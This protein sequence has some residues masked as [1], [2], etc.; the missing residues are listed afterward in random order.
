MV[1]VVE[2][3]ILKHCTVLTPVMQLVCRRHRTPFW[4]ERIDEIVVLA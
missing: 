3:F 1:M 4:G 2:L